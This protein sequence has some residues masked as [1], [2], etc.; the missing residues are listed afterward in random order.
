MGGAVLAPLKAPHYWWPERVWSRC[1]VRPGWGTPPWSSTRSTWGWLGDCL[2][3]APRTSSGCTVCRRCG[4][5][6]WSGLALQGRTGGPGTG[7]RLPA[8]SGAT[9]AFRRAARRW[10]R[11][12]GSSCSTTPR[13]APWW[14]RSRHTGTRPEARSVGGV[15][16]PGDSLGRYQAGADT[17]LLLG[18]PRPPVRNVCIHENTLKAKT[19]RMIRPPSFFLNLTLGQWTS[20]FSEHTKDW[21][22]R[23]RQAGRLVGGQALQHGYLS[24]MNT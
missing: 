4:V 22:E 15:C 24:W 21:L 23:E 12:P 18:V 14:E 17:E 2:P 20:T 7:G 8:W 10:C 3:P 13:G 5:G 11:R 6:W 1:S 9:R 16:S 19:L